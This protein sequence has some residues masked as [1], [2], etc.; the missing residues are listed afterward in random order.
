MCLGVCHD[1]APVQSGC[2]CNQVC[3]KE[4]ACQKANPF[5]ECKK[6]TMAWPLSAMPPPMRDYDIKKF[7][8]AQEAFSISL[9]LVFGYD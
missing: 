4:L 9:R 5:H 8:P 6:N 2:K 3:F 7:V 1:L